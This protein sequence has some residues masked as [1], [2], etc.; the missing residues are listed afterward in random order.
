MKRSIPNEEINVMAAIEISMIKA[1]EGRTIGSIKPGET[2]ITPIVSPR[3]EL[4]PVRV[5]CNELKAIMQTVIRKT[6]EM[7]IENERTTMVASNVR[8]VLKQI[9]MAT[10]SA[11]D[12]VKTSVAKSREAFTYPLKIS[13]WSRPV[14]RRYSNTPLFLSY[15]NRITTG[16]EKIVAE[17]ERKATDRTGKMLVK[18]TDV[19]IG[20]VGLD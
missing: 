14:D 2:G 4:A 7:A 1:Y 12:G 17:R 16:V 5:F 18:P 10:F 8:F 19:W 6:A 11:I 13:S 9:P 15:T 3:G 20:I